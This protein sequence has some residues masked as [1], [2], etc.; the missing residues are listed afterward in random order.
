MYRELPSLEYIKELFVYDRKGCLYWK[1]RP[2]KHF[3]SQ[4]DCDIWNSR[5]AYTKAGYNNAGYI[6][7]TI[8]DNA[9]QMH[10]LIWLI[11]NG[12]LKTTDQIDHINQDRSNNNIKNLR[13]VDN[14]SNSKN[15]KSRINNAGLGVGIRKSKYNSYNVSIYANGKGY[16]KTHKEYHDSL[17]WAIAKYKELQFDPNHYKELEEKLNSLENAVDESFKVCDKES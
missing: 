6:L 10:R 4:R 3:K 8:D 14:K 15:Q 16:F 17:E 1:H 9:Y 11:E 13:I 2:L 12:S 5:Y 7:V